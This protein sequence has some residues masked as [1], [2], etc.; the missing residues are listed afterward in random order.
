MKQGAK[1]LQQINIGVDLDTVEEIHFKFQQGKV[2]RLVD[3]P[4]DLV[5]R[6]PGSDNA[7]FVEWSPEDSSA[8]VFT[9]IGNIDALLQ[10]I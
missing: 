1:N 2:T 7:L 3:Y 8:A 9:Q 6:M 5:R 10:T 4:S